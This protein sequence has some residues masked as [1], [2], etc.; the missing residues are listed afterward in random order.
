MN[1]KTTREAVAIDGPAGAGKS[2]VARELAQALGYTYVDTGAMYRAVALAARR[3]GVEL[4]DPDA[5]GTVAREVRLDIDASGTRILLDGEDVSAEIRTP[6]VTAIT[7][8]A[9][10]AEP[11]RRV[12]VERQRLLARERAVVMEGRDITT[13]VLPDARWKIYLDASVE[14]RA[15]RRAKDLE[16]QGIAPDLPALEREIADRDRSDTE[17]EV[18]PLKRTPEQIYLDSSALRREETVARLCRMVR[19]TEPPPGGGA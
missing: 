18:G 11:V 17:R 2:T 19:G 16:A 8:Y 14:E 9:A 1:N 15:R 7:R 13:V 4:E 12:L 6:G 3:R 10:R 5:M